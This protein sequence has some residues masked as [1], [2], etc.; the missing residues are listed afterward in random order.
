MDVLLPA[1]GGLDPAY[2]VGGAVR[3]LLL[4]ARSVDLDVAIE[5]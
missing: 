4:G 2:L 3:D 1:L 5:G